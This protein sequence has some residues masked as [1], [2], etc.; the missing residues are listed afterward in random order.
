[1][2]SIYI[3]C[4]P[5]VGSEYLKG[6]LFVCSQRGP[7]PHSVKIHKTH[8][9]NIDWLENQPSPVLSKDTKIIYL[10]ADPRIAV[11]SLIYEWY[12]IAVVDYSH[13]LKCE[14]LSSNILKSYSNIF[15]SN[16]T[17]VKHHDRGPGLCPRKE[18]HGGWTGHS[19]LYPDSEYVNETLTS[20]EIADIGTNFVSYIIN[21]DFLGYKEH[22]DMWTK[23]P[24]PYERCIL[25][26][27]YLEDL[28]TLRSLEKFLGW[29]PFSLQPL[30]DRFRP[31]KTLFAPSEDALELSLENSYGDLAVEINKLDGF[32]RLGR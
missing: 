3:A 29:D 19:T 10:C 20:N 27:E 5:K 16:Q 15:G 1:M 11:M 2:S 8:E 12:S 14:K 13:T 32:T 28:E 7:R 4:Y 23:T 9:V 30:A 24:L 25:R 6:S 31:R 26:Y 22:F 21:N 18:Y 17:K